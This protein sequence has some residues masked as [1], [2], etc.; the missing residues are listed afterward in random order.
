MFSCKLKEPKRISE[1]GYNPDKGQVGVE[2]IKVEELLNYSFYS[3]ELRESLMNFSNGIKTLVYVGDI[4][5]EEVHYYVNESN[6]LRCWR[7]SI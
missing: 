5:E 4:N 6:L 1:V 7:S 3:L 2:W